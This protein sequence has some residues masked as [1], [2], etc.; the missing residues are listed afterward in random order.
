ML[1]ATA[2]EGVGLPEVEGALLA[3]LEQV[4]RDGI[5]EAE[6][7]RAKSQLRARLVFESDSVTNI[8]HQ[9]GYFETIADVGLYSSLAARISGVTVDAVGGA[10]RTLLHDANRTIGWFEPLQ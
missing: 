6:L 5:T 2:T 4:R 8:A 9:L 3:E 7:E 1:S 10:A